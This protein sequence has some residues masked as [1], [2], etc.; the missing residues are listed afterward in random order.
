MNL[1]QENTFYV[2]GDG[3]LG[4][5]DRETCQKLLPLTELQ[6]KVEQFIIVQSEDRAMMTLSGEVI[7]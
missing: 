5:S 6:P 7:S 2:Y 1:I 3:L 4:T